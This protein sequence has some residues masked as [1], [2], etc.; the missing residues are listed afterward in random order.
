MLL[1]SVIAKAD[2]YYVSTTGNDGNPGTFAEPWLTIQYGIN[3]I[4][5][6]D[7]L[8]IRGGVYYSTAQIGIVGKSGT[9]DSIILVATYPDDYTAGNRAIIDC[10]N[11]VATDGMW[12]RDVDYW[13]LDGLTIRNARQ[14]GTSG[15][16]YG[17][18]ISRS[19][20]I[21]MENMVSHDNGGPGFRAEQART[22]VYY[23][24]CDSY[25]N[26]DTIPIAPSS[27]GGRGAGFSIIGD[28]SE[29]D[30]SKWVQAYYT[31]CRAWDNSSSGFA[32]AYG[33][34]KAIYDSCW[35]I[36]VG[37]LEGDGRGFSTGRT[38]AAA[39][40]DSQYIIKN[41]ISIYNRARG[42]NVNCNGDAY[43]SN[44]V[45]LNNIAYNNGSGGGFTGSFGT[46]VAGAP[47]FRNNWSYPNAYKIGWQV[48]AQFSMEPGM[49]YS[50]SYNSW[51]VSPAI[52][53]T[54]NDFVSIDT[55]GIRG[56]RQADGGLPEI[57]F[58]KLKSTSDLINRGIDVGRPYNGLAPDLGAFEFV[59]SEP[60][61]VPNVATGA[62]TK[63]TPYTASVSYNVTFDGGG[64][65]VS[66]VCWS[67]SSDP[68]TADNATVTN[69]Q[70]GVWSTTMTGLLKNTTYYVRAYA[71]NASGTSYGEN[72]VYVTPTIVRVID[73]TTFQKWNGQFI[74]W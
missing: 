72:V 46:Q 21:Y 8:Y 14:D 70:E 33:V 51:D 15:V 10:D 68:T 63:L 58:L 9:A 48:D 1:V 32:A 19:E 25:N 30:T 11:L 39:P 28:V 12:M 3:Q 60:P 53:I 56:L 69:N 20:Y 74:D 62:V 41:S 2:I 55:A 24:N 50:S 26:A 40:P 71:T 22:I 43:T 29:T 6:G 61:D 35:V 59:E 52:T 36:G 49:N 57:N 34:K 65:V 54:D 37:T 38:T 42:Y 44:I 45:Y 16:K 47:I 5:R 67:T 27:P 66:G 31:G 4:Q 18:I 64:T 73:G 23:T 17:F 13:K 7:T